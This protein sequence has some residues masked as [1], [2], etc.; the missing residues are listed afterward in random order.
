MAAFPFHK[1]GAPNDVATELP[2]PGHEQGRESHAQGQLPRSI[3]AR[4]DP[5]NRRSWSAGPRL[6]T[7]LRTHRT[8]AESKEQLRNR[9]QGNPVIPVSSSSS[10]E[11]EP[12]VDRLGR[13]AMTHVHE[14]EILSPTVQHNSPRRSGGRGGVPAQWDQSQTQTEQ[15]PHTHGPGHIDHFGGGPMLDSSSEEENSRLETART[16]TSATTG[17]E[18]SSE[19]DAG[20]AVDSDE[21]GP[22][23]D[24]DE[25][26]GPA[27]DIDDASDGPAIDSDKDS[28]TANSSRR[29]ADHDHHSNRH[30]HNQR[31]PG[32]AVS[33]LTRIPG[34]QARAQGSRSRQQ[35]G[36]SGRSRSS[37]SKPAWM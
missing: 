9:A 15:V 35:S 4:Q 11:P 14:E 33:R 5:A 12:A 17:P 2:R 23:V 30:Y 27:V 1:D 22:A 36:G 3:N 6:T 18:V 21:N 26:D 8:G 10:F 37:G 13:N 34:P 32:S 31:R 28:D 24:S 20:P 19:E 7:R 29:S 25:E 16:N